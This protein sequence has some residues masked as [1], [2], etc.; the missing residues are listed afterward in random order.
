[1]QSV[2]AFSPCNITGFF[3]I[4]NNPSNPLRAGSTGAS[5]VL[6]SGVTTRIQARKSKV[7][8]VS[9]TF[10]G[11]IL[12][13][14]S[15]SSYVARKYIELEGNPWRIAIKHTSQ[16]PTGCGYGTSGAGALS[17]ALALNKAMK[18]SLDRLE[19]AQIAH[20]S[21]VRCKTGLGTVASVLAGGLALR[22]RPGAPG[23]GRTD[24]LQMP[25]DLRVITASFGPISTR[26]VLANVCLKNRVNVCSENL[27]SKLARN[28]P[29]TSFI[30]TS[31]K[32]ADCLSL[33]SGRLLRMVR[34]LDLLGFKSSMVMLGESLFC[35]APE[36]VAS[37]IAAIIQSWGLTP[38]VSRISRT[39]AH[40]L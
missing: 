11:R 25:A 19:A 38:A 24:R 26:K 2:A 31:R 39:G 27:I 28:N 15:V 14:S 32:F 7:A 12:S 9:A 21:E 5:V 6:S 16:L 35:T 1:M 33:M 30:E 40:L 18:L 13:Q 8:V 3:R 4:H 37:Q 23:V 22:K 36:G 17:L 10:N 29:T 20:I 34:S